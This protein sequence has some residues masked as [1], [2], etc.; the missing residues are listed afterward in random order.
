[1]DIRI[2]KNMRFSDLRRA[3]HEYQLMTIKRL[4]GGVKVVQAF[5]PYAYTDPRTL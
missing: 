4:V 3:P 5:L 2:M 1:M